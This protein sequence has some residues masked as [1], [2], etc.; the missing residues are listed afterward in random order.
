MWNWLRV[1]DS[2]MPN[3]FQATSFQAKLQVASY[4]SLF[5]SLRLHSASVEKT[6]VSCPSLL[7]LMSVSCSPSGRRKTVETSKFYMLSHLKAIH[8]ILSA[9]RLS[10]LL[11]LSWCYFNFLFF[12]FV[13]L[14]LGCQN[15]ATLVTHS[16]S[17][18]MQVGFVW[19]GQCNGC[20][21]CPGYFVCWV[22][23]IPLAG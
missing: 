2:G 8:W 13:F 5:D 3:S 22:P 10:D 14:F 23:I 19:F 21:F 7:L 20:Q 16:K 9:S 1:S 17:I 11:R 18:N 6:F 12:L 15:E 4:F